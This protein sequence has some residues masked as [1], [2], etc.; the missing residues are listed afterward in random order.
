MNLAHRLIGPVSQSLRKVSAIPPAAYEY[1]R[2]KN[3]STQ[4]AVTST[5]AEMVFDNEM[6]DTYNVFSSS[7]FSVPSLMNGHYALLTLSAEIDSKRA[8][9]SALRI[10]V[11]T[12]G[13]TLWNPII[14]TSHRESLICQAT[15]L[16]V[17]ATG[18]IYRSSYVG[19]ATP[20]TIQVSEMTYFSG[21]IMRPIP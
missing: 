8:Q 11:S 14:S 6:V 1:F 2:A 15:G 3:S 4:L 9:N 17:L 10:Q 18:N 5:H 19:G 12:D 21:I 13:G 16:V 20:E 7:R